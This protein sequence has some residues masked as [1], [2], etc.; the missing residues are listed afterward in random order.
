VIS[1]SDKKKR[2]SIKYASGVLE[3]IRRKKDESKKTS[4][5]YGF[6]FFKVQVARVVKEFWGNHPE[7]FEDIVLVGSRFGTRRTIRGL[8]V[9]GTKPE[10]SIIILPERKYC[11]RHCK[12][13]GPKT[14]EL[15]ITIDPLEYD[16]GEDI[17][18][19]LTEAL[20]HM[21]K[22]ATTKGE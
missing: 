6:E 21:T 13:L 15:V 14:Y 20:N 12:T 5:F 11:V 22:S 16:H 4:N 1:L 7:I 8:I 9:E 3:E 10:K 2:T 19:A 18:N 17:I